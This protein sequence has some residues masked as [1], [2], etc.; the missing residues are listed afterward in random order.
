MVPPLVLGVQVGPGETVAAAI[1]TCTAS[2]RIGKSS[3]SMPRRGAG[4]SRKTTPKRSVAQKP[5][6]TPVGVSALSVSWT[7]RSCAAALPVPS[8]SAA[9][10]R[11][12]RVER[13]SSIPASRS[14]ETRR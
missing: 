4:S 9:H 6:V 2:S 12:P 3:G 1:A 8:A 14:E 10:K 7:T 11:P 13:P 5:H